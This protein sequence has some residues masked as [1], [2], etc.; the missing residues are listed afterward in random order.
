MPSRDHMCAQCDAY[1]AAITAHDLDALMKLFAV[2]ASQEEPIGS[3][4]NV[5]LEEIRNFFDGSQAFP[6]TI[7]R[8]GP[9]TV[10]GAVA[11]FQIRVDFEGAVMPPMSS[12]D[13]V[14]F[15]EDGLI[16]SIIA[17]PDLAADPDQA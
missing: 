3:K 14:T 9:V 16:K 1:V 15:D 11:A 8:I 2:D 7:S 5:G 6:F 10:S 13:V 12:T 17:I 4:P